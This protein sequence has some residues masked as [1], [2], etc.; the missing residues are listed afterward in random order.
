MNI[1]EIRGFSM[2]HQK[3]VGHM[4]EPPP[5]V[6]DEQG[7]ESEDEPT[8]V[9]AGEERNNE[10]D[11]E[12]RTVVT[13]EQGTENEDEAESPVV[14][15]KQGIENEGEEE[16]P[17]PIDAINKNQKTGSITPMPGS[18]CP[19]SPDR[20]GT[21]TVRN[22]RK[23][24][25]EGEVDSSAASKTRNSK[26]ARGGSGETRI[27]EEVVNEMVISGI[28][29]DKLTAG[30]QRKRLRG[31]TIIKETPSIEECSGD[32]VSEAIAIS[33]EN[34]ISRSIGTSTLADQLME[35]PKIIVPDV[36][37]EQLE[38][39]FE[40]EGNGEDFDVVGDMRES[41]E[42][43]KNE[44]VEN[45]KELSKMRATYDSAL[46][47]LKAVK[48]FDYVRGNHVAA[49]RL[50]RRLELA[51]KLEISLFTG[52]F[53]DPYAW[54]DEWDNDENEHVRPKEEYSTTPV[55]ETLEIKVRRLP[56]YC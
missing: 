53:N 1:S 33:D 16:S 51:E 13:E 19:S 42:M 4:Y 39:A 36:V 2:P 20:H 12:P 28:E 55:G 18:P 52:N 41:M 44:L 48:E 30:P 43:L 7:N 45:D 32:V 38:G 46:S 54:T 35:G 15:E 56:S 26:K 11:D 37:G 6:A 17:E 9:V 3:F 10:S 29:S 40:K 27:T 24:K 49:D 23:R 5:V 31:S 25:G 34:G 47:A 14:T 21:R 8:R 22:S 50:E